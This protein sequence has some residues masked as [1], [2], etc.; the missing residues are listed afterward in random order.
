MTA[1]LW[2]PN[3][4]QRNSIGERIT[5]LSKHTIFVSDLATSVAFYSRLLRLEMLEMKNEKYAIFNVKN[6]LLELKVGEPVTYSG[7]NLIVGHVS[8]DVPD[9]KEAY[10]YLTNHQVCITDIITKVC[11]FLV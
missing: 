3:D 8:I 6:M 5:R 4:V 7:E 1:L 10:D 9:A 2:D 11:I